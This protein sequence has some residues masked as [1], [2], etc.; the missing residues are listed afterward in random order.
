[1]EGLE[2]SAGAPSAAYWS[3]KRVLITGATGMV[4]SW[5]TRWI[6]E[7]GAYT[8][9]FVADADPQSELIRS[10]TIK[11]INVVN[12]RLENYEDVER[13]IN[14]HEIDSIFH[15]GAQPIV[16]AANRLPRHT[17]ETNIQ[18]TWNLLD[19]ARVVAPMV[20]RI[21]VAS[22]DKAYGVQPHLPYT[23]QMSMNG[24]HPY[25]VSK[26]CTDL[27]AVTY[28]RTYGLPVTIARCG[29][30]YGGGDLNWN[31]IVPGTMRSLIRNEQPVLRSDG[32]FVRD[33]LHVD[34]IVTAYL[35]LGQ[36]SDDS[37]LWGEGFNFSNEE[38]LSVLEIVKQICVVADKPNVQ[39]LILNSA[40]GEIR[41][42]YLDSGK[43]H[44]ELGWSATTSLNE[45]LTKTLAWYQD[46][47][48]T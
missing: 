31:R 43:A 13:A 18:G 28:A 39:P 27:I 16:G 5:L 7:S 2:V 40:S 11:R 48:S 20:K 14:N 6:A 9:A 46:L 36:R 29:N 25:E 47:L 1:M 19:A 15:L 10:E 22:S 24:D 37:S 23:E 17:F 12:G 30:I 26:S 21:V 8:V 32:T 42:Q 41:D 44:R 35:T 34:D 38:P 3:E 4:G 45:G 33:Y